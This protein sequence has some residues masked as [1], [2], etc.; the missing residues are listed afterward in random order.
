ME[1]FAA[2]DEFRRRIGWECEL[3][4]DATVVL[5]S[6]VAIVHGIDAPALKLAYEEAV[7]DTGDS[8]Q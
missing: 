6:S 3:V 4:A 2:L 8:D 7:A 5:E 1:E